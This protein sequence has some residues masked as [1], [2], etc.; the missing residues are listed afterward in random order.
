[1]TDTLEPRTGQEPL[2]THFPSSHKVF[3]EVRHT[4]ADGT[5]RTLHVPKRRVHLTGDEPPID[6]YDT[7]GPLGQDVREGLPALSARTQTVFACLQPARWCC[8][9]SQRVRASSFPYARRHRQYP[10][11]AYF[12]SAP[13]HAAGA[14]DCRLLH[15]PKAHPDRRSGRRADAR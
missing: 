2:E 14:G 13:T 5:V 9:T 3:E 1:M 4:A 8:P 7:T 15:Q 10:A 12:R 11:P 6:L